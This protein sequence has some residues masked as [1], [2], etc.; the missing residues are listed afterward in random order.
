MVVE[1]HG[2]DPQRLT[3]LAHRE[4]LDPIFIREVQSGSKH[5]VPTQR[6]PTLGSHSHG[7]PPDFAID[8]FTLYIYTYTVHIR[9]KYPAIASKENEMA[10]V[11]IQAL[12]NNDRAPDDSRYPT[13]L[14]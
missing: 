2:L 13:E 11:A 5:L 6:E 14:I 7:Q 12:V 8:K 1:C 4:R 10:A 9:C 3:E